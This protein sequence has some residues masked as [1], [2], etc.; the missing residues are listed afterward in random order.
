[1]RVFWFSLNEHKLFCL[2]IQL[3]ILN[4]YCASLDLGTDGRKMLRTE[5]DG[6]SSLFYVEL[7]EGTVLSHVVEDNENFP[8]QFGRE[9]IYLAFLVYLL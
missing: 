6:K 1:M 3:H 9:V 5:F 2:S 8:A 4:S 7:P